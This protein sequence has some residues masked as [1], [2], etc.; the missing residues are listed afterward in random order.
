MEEKHEISNKWPVSILPLFHL[1]HCRP[2]VNVDNFQ[3]TILDL[4]P[5]PTEK[6]NTSNFSLRLLCG[7]FNIPIPVKEN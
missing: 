2:V 3:S 5:H 4:P 7:E 6:V 1:Y